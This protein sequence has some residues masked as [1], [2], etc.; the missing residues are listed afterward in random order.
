MEKV[1]ILL[2]GIGGY[3]AQYLHEFLDG[4]DTSFELAGVVD[5]FAASSPRFGELAVRSIPIFQSPEK[6]FAEQR[7]DLVIISSPIHTHYPYILTSLGEKSRVLCEKPVTASLAELD[8]LIAQEKK[9]GL[10]VAVGF[11]LC[12]S[13]DVHA[14]KKDIMSGLFGKPL[15]FKLS[16]SPAGEQSI[17]GTTAGRGN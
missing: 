14:L 7:A 16:V 9:T 13:R 6:F 4:N 1:Q 2:L 10:F 15:E 11:Q 5:P 8:E 3:G 17:T 12:Y